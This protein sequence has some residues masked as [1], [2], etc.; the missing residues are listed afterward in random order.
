M[1]FGE[2]RDKVKFVPLMII[3]TTSPG[4]G[5]YNP[6]RGIGKDP[7]KFTIRTRININWAKLAKEIPGPG[8]YKA[9]S[10]INK[11]GHYPISDLK[12][13]CATKF[14]PAKRF[15]TIRIIT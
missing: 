6:I 7:R 9:L 14:G 11:T 4:P 8:N 1:T 15:Q 12:D 3:N 13:S 5:T 2:A 10:T